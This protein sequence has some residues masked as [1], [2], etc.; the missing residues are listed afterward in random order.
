MSPSPI[1]RLKPYFK[2]RPRNPKGAKPQAAAAPAAQPAAAA[3]PAAAP[4]GQ[5]PA[6]QAAAAPVQAP[7]AQAQP[8]AA[9]AAPAATPQPAQAPPAPPPAELLARRKQLSQRY[10]ELESD[11]GGLVYEM[12]I[13]DHFRLDVLVRRAAELQAVDA[14]LSSVEQ[15]LGIATPAPAA[16]CP[17]C[18]APVGVGAQYCGRCGSTLARTGVPSTPVSAN[19]ATPPSNAD[20]PPSEADTAPGEADTPPSKAATP[21]STGV[22]P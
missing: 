20:T 13:R 4:A 16:V 22:T 5:A 8:A 18:R 9:P 21:P 7:A 3:A 19:A 15:A 12:A 1:K 14:E 17:A 6:A 11:L 2:T 10:A